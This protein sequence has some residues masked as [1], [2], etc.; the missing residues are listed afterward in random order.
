MHGVEGEFGFIPRFEFQGRRI[1][2]GGLAETVAGQAVSIDYRA[3]NVFMRAD[4]F[5]DGATPFGDV[6]RYCPPPT[7]VAPIDISPERALAARHRAARNTRCEAGAEGR[8]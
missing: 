3:L 1:E 5:L 2:A 7:I 4:V 6:R 8:A